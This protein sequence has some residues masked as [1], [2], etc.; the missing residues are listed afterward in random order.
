[1]ELLS[2]EG[3][4]QD[5]RSSTC[6]RHM[7][8]RLAVCERP[9]GSALMQ[10]GNTQV[11]ASV[12]GPKEAQGGQGGAPGLGQCVVRCSISRLAASGGERLRRPVDVRSKASQRVVAGALQ[13]AIKTSKYPGSQIDVCL[14]VVQ[15]DGGITACCINAACLALVHAGIEM[16]DYVTACTAC[17][18]PTATNTSTQTCALLDASAAEGS[19]GCEVTVAYLPSKQRLVALT[20]LHTLHR[21]QYD[22][23]LDMAVEGCKEVYETLNREVNTYISKIHNIMSHV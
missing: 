14:Q 16:T 23:V 7:R 12:Y 4:R 11:L 18:V 10:M 5:G 6:M 21:S 9:N 22:Q 13:A 2:P 15:A 17:A 8:C 20:S 1:M 3:L 19:G